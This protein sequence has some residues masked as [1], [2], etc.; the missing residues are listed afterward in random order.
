MSCACE[1][2]RDKNGGAKLSV[3]FFVLKLPEIFCL[4]L[5]GMCAPCLSKSKMICKR[6]ASVSGESPNIVG[7]GVQE[8]VGGF[9]LSCSTTC[10]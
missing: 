8:A 4:T 1:E 9:A 7:I 2:A 5:L 3:P 6:E 10:S